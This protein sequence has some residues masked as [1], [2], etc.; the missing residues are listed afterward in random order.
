VTRTP[1]WI[2]SLLNVRYLPFESK[3]EQY[4]KTSVLKPNFDRDGNVN[5]SILRYVLTLGAGSKSGGTIRAALLGVVTIALKRS[6]TERSSEEYEQD[7][8]AFELSSYILDSLYLDGT[9]PSSTA[10]S[11]AS[12]GVFWSARCK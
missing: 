2:K 11:D 1:N 3:F 9:S 6:W 12:S 10:T 7:F 5:F 4:A 8:R